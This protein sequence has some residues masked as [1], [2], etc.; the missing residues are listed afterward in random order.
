MDNKKLTANYA[1][2]NPN[3]VIQ[4]LQGNLIKSDNLATFYIV[5]NLLQRGFPTM[6]SQFLQE[7]LGELHKKDDFDGK[8]SLVLIDTELPKWY[9]TIKGHDITSK[10]PAVEFFE[11]LIP[12]YFGEY[13]FVQSLILPEVLINDVTEQETQDFIRQ[14][15]DFYLPQAKLVI[16]IDGEQ[17]KEKAQQKLDEIRDN[18]FKKFGVTT[19]RIPTENIKN[20]DA[21]F[22]SKIEDI[23]KRLS[24]YGGLKY[25]KESLE[26]AKHN[27][28]SPEEIQEK[29]LPTA[30][31]RFQLLVLE[32]LIHQKN[33][34]DSKVWHLNL[35]LHKAESFLHNLDFAHWAIEDLF[36][37]IENLCILR[38]LSF[39][40]PKVE[41]RKRDSNSFHYQEHTIYIDFS[42][43]KRYTD[44]NKLHE[45]V[46]FVRNDYF[47][48][49]KNYFQAS[50][51]T[52]IEYDI[53]QDEDSLHRKSLR[54]FLQNIFG[55]E[56]NDFRD[57]Q[58]PIIANA[59]KRRDS[60]VGLLPTGAG[61][62]LC[63][64]LPCLLQPSISF[65]VC[66]IKSLMSDQKENLKKILLTN[67]NFISSDIE[68]ADER[69][70]IQR[71]FANGQYLFV[72]ISPERFQI[73]EFRNYLA[74]VTS[75]I[76]YAV[77]DEVHC[78]SEWGHDFRTS[79]LNL[80]RTIRE[81]CEGAKIIGLTATASKHVLTDIEKTFDIKDRNDIKSKLNFGREELEFHIIK[82]EGQ[83]LETLETLLKKLEGKDFMKDNNQAGLIF[84]PHV[85]G[86][87]G[88]YG[89]SNRLN[90]KYKDK[91][92]WYSGS[93]PTVTAKVNIMPHDKDKTVWEI[94]LDKSTNKIILPKIDI[95]D[96]DKMREVIVN[97]L[98]A[99]DPPIVS[100]T[101]I[102]KEVERFIRVIQK[103]PISAGGKEIELGDT[104]AGDT[105]KL[106]IMT[107]KEFT[108]YK[109]KVQKDFTDD[110]SGENFPL[111]VATKAFGMGIDKNNI[112][113]TFHYG[114]PS[115]LESLYQEAGRAG[116][117]E[118]KKQKAHCYVLYSQAT[119]S[120][121]VD[122]ENIIEKIFSKDTLPEEIHNLQKKGSGDIFTQ[123][124]LFASGL[125]KFEEE[126]KI[127]TFLIDNYFSEGGNVVEIKWKEAEDELFK[128]NGVKISEKTGG[129]IQKSIYRLQILGMV[130]DWEVDYR[131]EMYRVYF[132]VGKPIDI[133]SNLLKHIGKY[134]IGKDSKEI[135]NEINDID[136][137]E[138]VIYLPEYQQNPEQFKMIYY[139]LQWTWD[140]VA[141]NRRKSLKGMMVLCNEYSS[142][143][144]FKKAID[145]IFQITEIT[146]IIQ[147][148]SQKEGIND[149]EKW[150]EVFNTEK[151]EKKDPKFEY[152]PSLG[153]DRRKKE[154]KRLQNN[155]SSYMQSYQ[156]N[157]ALNFISGI[158]QL[159]LNEY[160]KED[161]K[162]NLESSL[163]RIKDEKIKD[164]KIFSP[165]EQNYILNKLIDEIGIHLPAQNQEELV[166]SILLHYPEKQEYLA[167]KYDM[168]WLLAGVLTPL[169]TRFQTLNKQYYDKIR[170][171]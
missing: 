59:M 149:Y 124:F 125:R 15:V 122:S 92:K 50:T 102:Q 10:F 148:V 111:M 62:S 61:K 38:N 36:S 47:G 23:K 44:E 99:Q 76:A 66:P 134:D 169:L 118:N 127:I 2:T 51:T 142:S 140:A 100:E 33:S 20:K 139:L 29:L 109:K 90:G 144:E 93:V 40:R 163:Q 58:L 167:E 159:F 9:K 155:L 121:K 17:H 68:D 60:T 103:N 165:E 89:L 80:V 87:L 69:I 56:K 101:I 154:F 114:L 48:A 31:I 49:E 170:G 157:Y 117:W 82:D 64:Q 43:F 41:I 46:I 1:Y 28:F 5:K 152:L 7:K 138:G 104:Q 85:N 97:L 14:Q 126:A 164:G 57:G 27:S 143:E 156:Y 71:K 166:E 108:P 128:K 70:S 26:K 75:K 25:Y 95:Q 135:E 42:L 153:L 112:H 53:N 45:H 145:Q 81:K 131:N 35:H 171:I 132:S 106:P 129:I 11:K 8:N 37:W 13:A 21:A 19:V 84:T 73:L 18:H 67:T 54:F 116:R 115:S 98:K 110:K 78:M 86:G 150:F 161:G 168:P 65:V 151:D 55:K 77:I 94:Y 83:K 63:Y 4:N 141:F 6:M 123:T 88:C 72:W 137:M 16:E 158:I 32:L 130:K 119:F 30:I 160:D 136:K 107:D 113:Y 146:F 79:Y 12:Q 133:H 162:S 24:S 52:P 91:V 22:I 34:L 96:A 105:A 147:H 74:Q 120:D 3:F 39:K